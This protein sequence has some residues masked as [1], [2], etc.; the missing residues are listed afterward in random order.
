MSALEVLQGFGAAYGWRWNDLA[1]TR[2]AELVYDLVVSHF[3]QDPFFP[4]NRPLFSLSL[5]PQQGITSEYDDAHG[6]P[7]GHVFAKDETVFRCRNCGMDDTC[8]MCQ[9]CFRGSNHAGHDV[10]MSINAGSGGCCDCGD[11]EAWK[12]DIGCCYHSGDRLSSDRLKAALPVSIA[13]PVRQ[14]ISMLLDFCLQVLARAPDSMRAP[15]EDD[16]LADD[17]RDSSD[18]SCVLWNDEKHNFDEVIDI[19]KRA[20]R[21]PRAFGQSTA[22]TVDA[23]GRATVYTGDLAEALRIA[24]MLG[25]IRLGVTVRAACDVFMEDMIEV[26][27]GI[28]YDL[29]NMTDSTGAQP[30]RQL[31][32]EAMTGEVDVNVGVNANTNVS[33]NEALGL[34][35]R[36]WSS[37]PVI[38]PAAKRSRL[39]QLMLRD[40]RLWK[41]ARLSLRELYITTMVALPHF[42]AIMGTC[43]AL[44]YKE[45]AEIYFFADREP[46][47]SMIIF[48]VQLFTVP[49]ITAMLVREHHFL[50]H[51]LAVLYTYFTTQTP[52]TPRDVDPTATVATDVYTFRWKRHYHAI[53][54]LKYILATPLV[55]PHITHDILLQ[56][57]DW[58]ELFHGMD[59]QQRITGTHVEYES[60]SWISAF[61]LT[62]QLAKQIESFA[63]AFKDRPED[64]RRAAETILE[65]VQLRAETPR[66]PLFEPRQL[67]QDELRTP[68]GRFLSFHHPLNWLLSSLVPHTDSVGDLWVAS[69]VSLRVIVWTWEIRCRQWVRNGHSIVM[70]MWHYT[71]PLVREFCID[72]DIRLVQAWLSEKTCDDRLENLQVLDKRFRDVSCVFGSLPAADYTGVDP[73]MIQLHHH[74][75]LFLIG[76]TTDRDWILGCTDEQIV[77]R[78][79]RHGLVFGPRAY[80]D[81]IK[82]VSERHAD[83][84]CFERA[85]TA[86]ADFKPPGG[87]DDVGMYSLKP[88]QKDLVDPYYFHYSRSQ[89]EEAVD[90]IKKGPF[91][92]PVPATSVYAAVGDFLLGTGVADWVVTYFATLSSLDDEGR[93][94]RESLTDAVV[95]LCRLALEQA[96]H[97]RHDSTGPQT[98]DYLREHSLLQV[99]SSGTVVQRARDLQEQVR[100]FFGQPMEVEA[101][102]AAPSD[103]AARKKALARARQAKLLSEMQASQSAFLLA[104]ADEEAMSEDEREVPD[105]C[106]VCQRPFTEGELYG[107]LG[108]VQESRLERT[109]NPADDPA[110]LADLLS[111]PLTMDRDLEWEP[112][113]K[114]ARGNARE[115]VTT[116][117]HMI[118]WAC[119]TSFTDSFRN[120]LLRLSSL[121]RNVPLRLEFSCPLCQTVRNIFLPTYHREVSHHEEAAA[122]AAV[123]APFRGSQYELDAA[124]VAA[125]IADVEIAL[126]D[127]TTMKS[128]FPVDDESCSIISGITDQSAMALRSIVE[129]V[130]RRGLSSPADSVYAESIV[131]SRNKWQTALSASSS[132]DS[133]I[134]LLANDPFEVL[135][136]VILQPGEHENLREDIQKLYLAHVTRIVLLS[137]DVKPAQGLEQSTPPPGFDGWCRTT[138]HQAFSEDRLGVLWRLVEMYSLPFVRRTAILV[139]MALGLRVAPVRNGNELV[140]LHQALEIPEIRDLLDG[141]LSGAWVE[142]L[143]RDEGQVHGATPMT[144]PLP[145]T[146]AKLPSELD[147]LLEDCLHTRCDACG[148]VPAQP[149][150]CLLCGQ[151]VCFQ[152][153]CCFDSASSTGECTQHRRLC[154]GSQGIF[155]IPKRA[156]LLFLRH[157]TGCF[158]PPPY[159]DIHGETDPD[160]KRGKPQFLSKKRY[161]LG[162]RQVYLRHGLA[163]LLA[164]R[165]D[166]QPD[167]GGWTT[168]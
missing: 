143:F 57:V 119:Y 45:L 164:R 17:T 40:L 34:V 107:M 128:D 138:F 44:N 83:D 27:V 56:F 48:S 100:E 59:A 147:R 122:A 102:E 60:E 165:Y 67:L 118:H 64:A 12:T 93:Q 159:L 63:A 101:A 139:N 105:N 148:L 116:C 131:K 135:V 133:G 146:L 33:I 52:G 66:M 13:D 32:C 112:R 157:D 129:I 90:K 98:A 36:H 166:N 10:V 141:S 75:I 103:E 78:E 94:C 15:T 113:A 25:R 55:Y 3:P 82:L 72:K 91:P 125:S 158:V 117:G 14:T 21:K 47:H 132:T 65:R 19:V 7:C 38:P 70:Q 99:F 155:L 68:E 153:Q 92:P 6:R 88:G 144:S 110:A 87:L 49:S 2:L 86:V 73:R 167:V 123:A 161:E 42:K 85:L 18:F 127:K 84:P 156:A 61:N 77:A 97:L 108:T 54:D 22:T 115:V 79:L 39:A 152:T 51:L 150:V 31:I 130:R 142:H 111:H 76:L 74:L 162:V 106:M 120:E 145:F 124:I 69:V 30:V 35:P 16:V 114:P 23:R 20:C 43:F 134:A 11:A 136:K 121:G 1:K 163:T 151:V 137:R 126:R 26:I 81:L 5:R 104:N 41:Q 8:V 50:T 24:R 109:S 28:L 154:S 37:C 71:E 140:R 95:Q 96:K 149:A 46:E 62:L 168:L 89:S 53:N 160:L 9:R 29:A 80:S 58:L 4:S